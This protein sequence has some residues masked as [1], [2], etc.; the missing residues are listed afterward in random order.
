M[1]LY[2][3]VHL[4]RV[5]GWVLQLNASQLK[6]MIMSIPLGVRLDIPNS[7]KTSNVASLSLLIRSL[8]LLAM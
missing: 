2:G 1:T 5:S 8:N 7:W 4:N 6:C 3:G